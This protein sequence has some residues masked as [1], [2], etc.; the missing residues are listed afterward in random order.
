MGTAENTRSGTLPPAPSL[1][2]LS[3][4]FEWYKGERVCEWIELMRMTRSGNIHGEFEHEPQ[5]NTHHAFCG[6]SQRLRSKERGK[7]AADEG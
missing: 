4:V 1:P 3:S 7:K 2:F 5:E 6:S